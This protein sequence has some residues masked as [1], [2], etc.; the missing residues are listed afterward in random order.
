MHSEKLKEVISEKYRQE[1]GQKDAQ[2]M[3]GWRVAAYC[4]NFFSWKLGRGKNRQ[5][6]V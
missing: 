5:N 1:R 2:N 4:G 6:Y 3:A